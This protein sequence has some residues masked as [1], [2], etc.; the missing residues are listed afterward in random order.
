[1]RRT[2]A[3]R[4]GRVSTAGRVLS[5]ARAVPAAR[6]LRD[7]LLWAVLAAPAIGTAWLGLTGP[8]PWWRQA[9]ALGVLAVAAAV[10][11]LR[12]VPALLLAAALGFAA[13]PSLFTLSYGPAL[14]VLGYLLGRR[15]AAPRPAQL[16]FAGIA[17]VGTALV[18]LRGADPVIEWLVLIGTLL[19]G[20][21]FPWLTG[22]YRRQYRELVAAGWSRAAQLEREQE[23]VADRARLRERARIARDMHDSLGHELSLIALRAGALQ[24]APGLD[25]AHRTAAADLRA[26]AAAATDRLHDIIGVLR[27][28]EPGPTPPTAPLV[29]ADETIPAL[30]ERAASSGLCVRLRVR[31]ASGDGGAPRAVA[32]RGGTVRGGVP[33]EPA[34]AGARQPV[35]LRVRAVTGSGEASTAVVGR[36]EAVRHGAPTGAAPTEAVPTGAVPT[37]AVPAGAGEPVRVRAASG[38]GGLPRDVTGRSGAVRG[39]SAGAAPAGAGEPVRVRAVSGDGGVQRAAAGGAAGARQLVPE[40]DDSG[41]AISAGARQGASGAPTMAERAAYRVVQEAL[42]NAAKHAPGAEVEVTV[43]HGPHET[44]VTV[45][46]GPAS[47]DAARPAA[48]G[49]KPLPDDHGPAEPA[50]GAAAASHGPSTVGAAPAAGGVGQTSGICD[51]A[52]NISRAAGAGHGPSTGGGVRASA[53]KNPAPAPPGN[54]TGLLG[55]RERAALT[56]GE[57][58]A[59]PYEGGFRVV[60]RLPH[61]AAGPGPGPAP[62][63]GHAFTRARRAARR[64]FAVP[65]AVAGVCAALFVAG[66][67]GWYAYIKTHSVLT[68]ADYAGLRVGAPYADVEPVLPDL[69]VTDPPA[70][71]AVVPPPPGAQCRY[72]RSTGELFVSVDHFRLCFRDGHLVSKHAVPRVGVPDVVQQE[73]KEWVR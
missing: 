28:P 35:R 64:R 62:G 60:A 32:G 5:A 55:L 26:A 23:I 66:A 50:G 13:S 8:Q 71:R 68:P 1:M 29:P 52:E 7:A 3:P 58:V 54:G 18:L 57:C 2:T 49:G 33:A 34:A 43:E 21:V 44:V 20:G 65:F 38:G 25:P 41:G 36:N 48:P 51:P 47:A 56:G 72:Y 70:D 59:G 12:P 53:R 24:V 61:T 45:V 42:T 30:V 10:S 39:V 27:D 22:R 16:A 46:N 63:D 73:E 11:R 4:T 40:V 15:S 19:F 31:A 6:A 69:T 67:F 14:S 17:A 9:G 37:E